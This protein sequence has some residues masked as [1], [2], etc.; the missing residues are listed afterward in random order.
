VRA[1]RIRH[2]IPDTAPP[3][4]MIINLEFREFGHQFIYDPDT[5]RN[6]MIAA[7]F[8]NVQFFSVGQSGSRA[9]WNRIAGALVRFRPHGQ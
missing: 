7:N 9:N 3:A 2:A 4:C 1:K 5:L 6:S 8:K